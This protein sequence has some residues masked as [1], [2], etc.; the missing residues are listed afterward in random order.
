MVSGLSG[1]VGGWVEG[2]GAWWVFS[3]RRPLHYPEELGH[4]RR[5]NLRTETHSGAEAEG[6]WAG[7]S[8]YFGVL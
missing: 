7:L 3:K 8:L 1:W 5:T 6:R 4:D 2:A